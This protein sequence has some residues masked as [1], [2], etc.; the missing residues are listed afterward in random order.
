MISTTMPKSRAPL[1]AMIAAG[2]SLA[3]AIVAVVVVVTRKPPKPA[4]PVVED[5]DI[6][7][8]DVVA[9][10]L[11]VPAGETIVSI[12]GIPI[13]GPADTTAVLS[14][15]AVDDAA[16]TIFVEID[17]HG[18]AVV[19]R[20]HVTGDLGDAWI[21]AHDIT[22]YRPPTAPVPVAGGG[23]AAD[24]TAAATDPDDAARD[25]VL[26]GFT[27][28]DDTHY[29]IT[30]AAR[31]AIKANSAGFARGARIVPAM[32]NGKPQGLKLYAIRPNSAFA[33]LGLANGDTVL[34][35]NG[36][37]LD[38]AD[39]ALAAYT[40]LVDSKRLVVELVRRGN[41]LTLHYTIK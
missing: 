19:R 2:V 6:A 24:P 3:V 10:T 25:A 8:A 15:L 23:S 34:T 29:Q 11:A 17:R 26:A 39:A 21:A 31:D 35:V 37:A 13:H 36:I 20:L 30:K 22:P 5:A 12:A 9:G 40:K 7:A 28:L 41:P 32:K 18:T 27:T 1:I 16:S 38:G 14:E 33:H 4:G